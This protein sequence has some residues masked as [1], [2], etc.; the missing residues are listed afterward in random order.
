MEPWTDFGGF[1]VNFLPQ[2]TALH[3]AGSNVLA[4]DL[5]NHGRSGVGSGGRA[6]IGLLEYR[7]MVGSM[8]YAKARKDTS[9]MKTSL[10]SVCLG[11][12]STIVA[13]HKHPEEFQHVHSMI[14]LQP[15]SDSLQ[16]RFAKYV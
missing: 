10:I 11:C 14:A 1:E 13:L 8:R 15:V 3:D 4:Y 2:Y 5:C 6:G 9:D 16:R 7:D 12:N